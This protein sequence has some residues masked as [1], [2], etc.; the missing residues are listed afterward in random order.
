MRS[1]PRC[2]QLSGFASPSIK[3]FAPALSGRDL[4]IMLG[5]LGRPKGPSI[6]VKSLPLKAGAKLFMLGDAK[7]LSWS[8]RGN[9]LKVDLPAA[10]PAQ[11]AYVIKIVAPSGG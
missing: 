6:I 10:L 4:T 11:Y 7:P 5:P 9:D 1:C 8:Q 2:D 3:S